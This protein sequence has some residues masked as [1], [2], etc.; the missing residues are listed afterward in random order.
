MRK[1]QLFELKLEGAFIFFRFGLE[2]PMLLV[3]QFEGTLRG[4]RQRSAA[5][6]RH[7]SVNL[8]EA[9]CAVLTSH[10]SL[11]CDTLFWCS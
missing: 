2:L 8:C 7:S 11:S 10:S 1:L 6:Q 4:F 3:L 9:R 5:A